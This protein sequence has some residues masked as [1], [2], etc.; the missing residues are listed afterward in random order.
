M[1]RLRPYRGQGE[2]P[3]GC[4]TSPGSDCF[5]LETFLEK[6]KGRRR[7]RIT[8]ALRGALPKTS[9]RQRACCGMGVTRGRPPSGDGGI[10]VLRGPH[11]TPA[12]SRTPAALLR[13]GSASRRPH[14]RGGARG[15]PSAGGRGRLRAA[16]P[17]G[18]GR[19]CH[20]VCS[21]DPAQRRP[22]R[23]RRVLRAA[24]GGVRR[25]RGPGEPRAGPAGTLTL[26]PAGSRGTA[27]APG[28]TAAPGQQVPRGNGGRAGVNGSRA[29]GRRVSRRAPAP[30]PPG[31]VSPRRAR[32][33]R[34]PRRDAALRGGL[35][36]ARLRCEAPAVRPAP[37]AGS[38]KRSSSH[39]AALRV[40]ETPRK[41]PRLLRRWFFHVNNG[42]ECVGR[43]AFSRV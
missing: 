28:C 11:P 43:S 6:G 8:H 21:P 10:A 30:A 42:R 35:S 15:A 22:P 3:W 36:A 41:S 14:G 26:A 24:A 2:R 4:H 39:R 23:R 18:G 7:C 27:A 29:R 1:F 17:E 40:G 38:G 33:R 37:P 13:H 20:V 16:P 5:H 9:D 34:R 31:V 25:Y 32:Y 19:R 12:A